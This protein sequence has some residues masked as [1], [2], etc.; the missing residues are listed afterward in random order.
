MKETYL[1]NAW[2]N[3][4]QYASLTLS[5]N[6]KM[7][8]DKDSLNALVRLN[9]LFED[10]VPMMLDDGGSNT[11]TGVLYKGYDFQYL[12]Q[13]VKTDRDIP[14]TDMTLPEIRKVLLDFRDRGYAEEMNGLI[15][16]I[17]TM[18]KVIDARNG[19]IKD[20][21]WVFN[22][23]SDEEML[24]IADQLIQQN[25]I[26]TVPV[27]RELPNDPV[28]RLVVEKVSEGTET[29]YV[30]LQKGLESTLDT[31]ADSL[32]LRYKGCY[33]PL[34]RLSPYEMESDERIYVSL[35]E[36]V[37]TVNH[38]LETNNKFLLTDK[39][40]NVM[41]KTADIHLDYDEVKKVF[42]DAY[43]LNDRIFEQA[44]PVIE[45]EVER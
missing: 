10:I 19:L 4:I 11:A 14:T 17:P 35:K 18:M 29:E 42:M 31:F 38:I 24:L 25:Q 32:P 43:R 36:I 5:E 22:S 1:S 27:N 15:R 21:D 37:D 7:L 39:E 20:F 2:K 40:G 23:L 45:E 6:G 3:A 34:F 30:Q 33:V 8:V 44:T 26:G 41:E 9:S 13:F 28:R 12:E 16:D